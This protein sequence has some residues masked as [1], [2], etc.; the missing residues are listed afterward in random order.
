M[1]TF[2]WT[3][4]R[5]LDL[6]SMPQVSI[7]DF[8]FPGF[9][10][11]LAT[12]E[13]LF[14]GQ[15]SNH[16]SFLCLCLV[17]LYFV[18]RAT[19]SVWVWVEEH[20]TSTVQ[21]SNSSE[22]RD[23]VIPWLA[24]QHFAQG[25]RSLLVKIRRD[26]NID[27]VEKKPLSYSPYQGTF[28]FFYRGRLLW[29]RSTEKDVGFHSE[30]VLKISCLGRSPAIVKRLLD[31]CRG[32]YLKALEG[33]ISIFENNNDHWRHK[34]AKRIRPLSTIIMNQKAKTTLISDARTFVESQR[35]YS[36]RGIPHRR[37]Y[38]LYGRPGGGKS[39]LSLALAGHFGLEIY[40]LN[41]SNVSASTLRSLI[42]DLPPRCVLLLEDVDAVDM[43]Q[44]RKV[45]PDTQAQEDDSSMKRSKTKA[46]A[47]LSLSDLLNVL[48]GV[49]AQEGRILVMTS[50]H[51]EAL[52]A[53]LIRPGRVDLKIELPLA[54]STV[55]E[56]LFCMVFK[57]AEGDICDPER[58]AADDKT[59]ERLAKEFS[60]KVPGN[61]LSPAAIQ[62]Y[63]VQHKD[64]PYF[65]IEKVDEWV[66]SARKEKT[67]D[68]TSFSG[69]DIAIEPDG[70]IAPM[71]KRWGGGSVF[72]SPTPSSSG[73]STP[74]ATTNG[75][76]PAPAPAQLRSATLGSLL[77]VGLTGDPQGRVIELDRL[78]R[79]IHDV[80][81][82]SS[83]DFRPRSFW[84]R[85]QGPS[86]D[87]TT[88]SW[89]ERRLVTA[90]RKVAEDGRP[91][92]M[93]GS[94]GMQCKKQ[95]GQHEL[96]S[97]ASSTGACTPFRH[98][99]NEPAATSRDAIS[100]APSCHP[101]SPMSSDQ[102]LLTVDQVTSLIQDTLKQN[103]CALA[104]RPVF[105]CLDD[106]DL[107]TASWLVKK[108]RKSLEEFAAAKGV[109][110]TPP[111]SESGEEYIAPSLPVLA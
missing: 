104:Q 62:S 91:V 5:P 71:P 61:T 94:L 31:D 16:A 60:A 45:D 85:I 110:N 3:A 52:D 102:N 95:W 50:N 1:A 46:K 32:A 103:S 89:V 33:K 70:S 79:L 11:I 13:Q 88:A 59:V 10:G 73:A 38:L 111:P 28:P 57:R 106:P 54:N 2:N 63:L 23:M 66:T 65:A 29:L 21:I 34:E 68:L 39:S 18:K 20:L 55:A 74:S 49:S 15:L 56:E 101:L 82:S 8:F 83:D 51:P 80:F 17:A 48:D 24:S 90:I 47:G 81:Q 27:E 4:T 22:V 41:F 44:S 64:S 76:A 108:L 67:K 86:E 35:W 53:A 12:V 100:T 84:S 58:S 72:G 9:S 109:P 14:A 96:A 87:L 7:L 6:G 43:T 30:E 25:A 42:A 92:Q 77:G 37:G 99:P 40:I 75:L 105:D 78:E 107:D 97:S 69:P 98:H 36:S 26:L 19:F 93:R